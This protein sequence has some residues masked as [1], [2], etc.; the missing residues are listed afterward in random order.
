MVNFIRNKN[1]NLFHYKQYFAILKNFFWTQEIFHSEICTS[2]VQLHMPE[3][4][5]NHY[6]FYKKIFGLMWFENNYVQA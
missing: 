1:I 5:P 4:D 3:Y 6:Y 2:H